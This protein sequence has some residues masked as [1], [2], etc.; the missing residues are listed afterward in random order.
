MSAP[1]IDSFRFGRVVIDGQHYEKDIIILPDAVCPN[2]WR[3]EGHRLCSQDLA[4]VQSA[5]PLTLIIG[6]GVFGR[7]VVPAAVVE[8]MEAR[9]ISMLALK[10]D[11]ACQ[12]YNKLREKER[13]AAALHLTC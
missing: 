10:T 2:W 13:V 12:E 6:T 9:G 5:T 11:E 4:S 3:V 8:E 7:L 1:R